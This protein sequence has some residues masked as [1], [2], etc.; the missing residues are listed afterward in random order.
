[1]DVAKIEAVEKMLM[2]I[3]PSKL[4]RH[5]SMPKLN[6]IIEREMRVPW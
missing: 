6:K 1:M 4:Q 3:P 5:G 2:E